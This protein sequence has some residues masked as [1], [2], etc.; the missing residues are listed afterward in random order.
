MSAA[1][2]TIERNARG[3]A[4]FAR[5]D[6]KRHGKKLMDF[7]ASN[8]VELEESPYDPEFVAKIRQSEE[9][10]AAGKFKVIRT[11]DLWK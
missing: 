9:Q 5:I 11:E 6:L 3:E 4:T 10:I 7:F 1:G 2:I 8:H